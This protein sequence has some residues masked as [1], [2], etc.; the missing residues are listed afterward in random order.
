[1]SSIEAQ[2]CVGFGKTHM[3]TSSLDNDSVAPTLLEM[4]ED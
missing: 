4:G 1:M 2:L 3:E